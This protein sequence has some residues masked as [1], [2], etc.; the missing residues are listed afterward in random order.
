MRRNEPP[1][2]AR[3]VRVS[4]VWCLVTEHDYVKVGKQWAGTVRYGK[5]K[6]T[7]ATGYWLLAAILP[8]PIA[9]RERKKSCFLALGL[10]LVNSI[11]SI[12]P[13]LGERK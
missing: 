7:G 4:C 9:K 2:L 5:R 11:F 6:E 8:L 12:R 10:R 1:C 13:P 3:A